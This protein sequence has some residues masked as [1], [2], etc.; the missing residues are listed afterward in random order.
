MLTGKVRPF[1][2]EAELGGRILGVGMQYN[3]TDKR[4][5]RV[6]RIPVE[7]STAGQALS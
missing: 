6:V 4:H 3:G 7:T 1:W 5:D 2:S